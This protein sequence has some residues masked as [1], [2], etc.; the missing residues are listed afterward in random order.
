V[1]QFAGVPHDLLRHA[2][3]IDAGAA[4][5]PHLDQ[6]RA[7]AVLGRALGAGQSAA[8]AAD[9]DQV[10]VGCH[11]RKPRIFAFCCRMIM[12][13]RRVIAKITD[14][15][16]LRPHTMSAAIADDPTNNP[17]LEDTPLPRFD[18]IR[19]EH[20]EPAISRLI[21]EQRAR[22]A[23]IEAVA[24][25]TFKTVVEPLEELRHRLS[26]VWS[27]IGHLNAVMNSEPLRAAYNACLPMLSDYHT[28]LSQSEAAVSCLRADFRARG[29]DTRCR[30]A[31]GDRARAARVS[32]G[33]R[34]ARCRAQ[35]AL[36]GRDDGA[37]ATVGEVRGERAR[38][39]QCLV[40]SCH[41]PRAARRPQRRDRRA[42][43]ARG[44]AT[45]AWKAGCSGWISPA[46]WRW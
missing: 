14:C 18:A 19:P 17:L 30:T 27:P 15:H 20:V 43:G 35:G 3:D 36:Q 23:Q 8:A 40:A 44:R 33:R 24:D 46:T 29:P 6:Q 21:A 7:G 34:R 11:V 22:V 4:Q 41:R 38:C 42:G 1:R 16:A 39:H 45:R 10:I 31:R 5:A 32:P 26:R 37:V 2:A 12:L 28:D 9:D 13:H 25:P